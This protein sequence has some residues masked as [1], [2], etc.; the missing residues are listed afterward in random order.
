MEIYLLRHGQAEPGSPGASDAERSLTEEG[1]YEIQRVIAAAKLA[2]ACPSLILSSPYKRALQ[3]AAIAADLLH[4]KDRVLTS[5]ALAPDA[6]VRGVWE[7]IRVHR[8]EGCLLLAGHEPLLSACTAY[9]LGCPELL[10][11]FTK[12]GL[13]RMDVE[14]FGP[15]P[16]GAL[17]WMLTPSL[18]V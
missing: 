12:A 18:T 17:K 5:D 6:G 2:H 13:L 10:V 1:R 9:L 3:S 4:Y 11:D 14:S 16:R 15:E 8:D 7:E